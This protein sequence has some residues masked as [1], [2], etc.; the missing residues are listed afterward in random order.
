MVF[1]TDSDQTISP[2]CILVRLWSPSCE[3]KRLSFRHFFSRREVEPQWHHEARYTILK[4][5]KKKKSVG[6]MNQGAFNLG[7][8]RTRG[9]RPADPHP[10]RPIRIFTRT[11][12]Y[13]IGG[14]A[15]G[16][17]FTPPRKSAELQRLSS[18][19]P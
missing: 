2:E 8:S 6:F 17:L 10:P 15:V 7:N 1:S 14:R 19:E 5:P 16:R 12:G 11:S 9:G 3:N 18:D 4:R 13:V